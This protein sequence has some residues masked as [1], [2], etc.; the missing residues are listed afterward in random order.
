MGLRQVLSVSA[1][2]VLTAAAL[3]GCFNY[4]AAVPQVGYVNRSDVDVR[5]LVSGAED[6]F[7]QPV[8]G[9][10]GSGVAIDECFGSGL[11]VQDENGEVIGEV[12]QPAC[13]RWTLTINED[14]SLTYVEND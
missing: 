10:N 3:A 13:P 7:E 6:D 8:P 5:V 2:A 11:R 9:Q 1:V 4:D 12:D 14:M